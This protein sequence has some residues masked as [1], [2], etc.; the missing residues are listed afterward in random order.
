MKKRM[1]PGKPAHVLAVMLTF[2]LVLALLGGSV[3]FAAHE[4][5]T[6]KQ[7]HLNTATN[8]QVL[9]AQRAY[10]LAKAE[11]LAEE[12]PF[13]SAA[14]MGLLTDD[15]LTEHN[16]AAVSWWM[17]LLGEKPEV[18]APS[19]DARD[20]E[21]AVRDDAVFQEH[22]PAEHRRTVARDDIAYEM[23]KAVDKAV[24]PVR[25]ELI[26]LFMPKVLEKIDV[27]YYMAYLPKI[28]LMCMAL[29]VCMALL[30]LAVM[31]RR[32]SKALLYIGAGL[33]AGAACLVMLGACTAML[34]LPAMVEEI[35]AVLALQAR[36]TLRS[37]TLWAGAAAAGAFLAGMA[38][39]GLHQADMKR[40]Y[41]KQRGVQA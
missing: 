17:G 18:E 21:Q 6:N 32:L 40:F 2:V 23:G 29:A 39:I 5:L 19:W 36:M 38:L 41:K 35:S 3:L 31:H 9:E 27:P 34:G 11:A 12:H 16:T 13:S 24:M 14:V 8:P 15:A 30:L 26:S 10:V 25:T 1:M 37:V 4:M 33:A 22:T 28:G 7:L 20:M